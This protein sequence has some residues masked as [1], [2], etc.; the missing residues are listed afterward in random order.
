MDD[1]FQAILSVNRPVPIAVKYLFDFLDELAEKH[2]IEDL[3][4]LHIWKTNRCLVCCP[5][6]ERTLPGRGRQGR[7]RSPGPAAF[8]L[9][10][11]LPP[12][13][14][15]GQ[16]PTQL[17]AGD[18]AEDGSWG[19]LL[20]PRL[21]RV[22]SLLL[23]FWVNTLKNP[24]LIFDVRVSDNVD[25]VLTV[26][27]QTF[28]DS[29]TISEHKVGRVRAEEES[30]AGEP[31]G[32]GAEPWVG[33][34]GHEWHSQK[35]RAELPSSR[36]R[37]PLPRTGF[38]REQT[39]LRPG[40]PSLQ[41]DGGEVGVGASRMREW[42]LPAPNSVPSS[43]YY[44]DIRQSSP[45][46][47]QEMNSALAELSGVRPGPEGAPFHTWGGGGGQRGRGRLGSRPGL[48]PQPPRATPRITPPLPTVWKLCE[49][50]TPTSTG[51]TTR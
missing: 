10:S 43:R 15:A 12:H 34:G 20:T 47:Y 31:R 42:V 28:M 45:A 19:S 13:G 21:A 4:T 16:L 48:G 26:I 29:C 49:N 35:A 1:A 14:L 37:P 39:A 22:P 41:A 38:P 24:Q 46:S 51:T 3:E 11:R 18:Q 6:A 7:D 40:D 8:A 36:S 25:A 17:R 5:R 23:R 30:L 50:S 33:L 2:G 9:G 32:L 27:A 44:S